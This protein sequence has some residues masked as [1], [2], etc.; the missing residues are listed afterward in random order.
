MKR[1]N[2]LYNLVMSVCALAVCGGCT[3]DPVSDQTVNSEGLTLEIN[4][5]DTP[6]ASV[7]T[8][9]AN[10]VSLNESNVNTVDVFFMKDD[11]VEHYVK[12][13][14]VNGKA[15]LANG[16]WKE[17]Y[18]GI[19]DVYVLANKHDYDNPS[20]TDVETDLS[21]VNNKTQ[22]LALTD[23]DT[24]VAKAEDEDYGSTK[25]SGKTFLMDGSISWNADD[26]EANAVIEVSLVHASAKLTV[27]LTY[28]E[29]FLTEGRKIVSVSKKLVHYVQDVKAFTEG[30]A[31]A[32]TEV[33]GESTSDGFSLANF[34][35]GENLSRRDK[36]YAYSYPNEWGADIAERET[37]FLINIPYSENDELRQNYYKVPVRIS[38]NASE[39]KLDRNMEYTVNVTVDRVGNESIDEPVPLKPTFSVATWKPVDINVDGDTPNYLVV[40]DKELEMHN[41]EDVAITFFSSSPI[42]VEIVSAY[43]VNKSG[44][45]VSVKND[46]L[47]STAYDELSLTGEITVHSDIPKNVTA[48]YITLKVTNEDEPTPLTQEIKIIQY[49]LEYISGVPGWYSTRDKFTATWQDHLDGKSFSSPPSVSNTVFSSK[50]YE[51]PY[52]YTYVV[53]GSGWYGDNPPFTIELGSSQ[54]ESK[55]NNRMYLVQ[56]TSTSSGHTVARPT[57]EGTGDD[58]V[59][60]SNEENNRLVSPVFMLA[61][62]LGTVTASGW[63]TAQEHCKQYVEWAKYPD[64]VTRKFADWRLPTFSELQIIAQYQ[65]EQPE[66]MDE[67]LGGEYYWSAYKNYCIIRVYEGNSLWGEYTD[68]WEP[69]PSNEQSDCFIRCI[70]DVTPED[71]EEF[72]AH[73]IQ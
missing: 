72:R 21:W 24:N 33:Q 32:L 3:E 55:S 14:V 38:G 12:S 47:I 31:L 66:V 39:L 1:N 56:I 60:Q 43:F 37:Y 34:T 9:G 49:P 64:G 71:L 5:G 8:R 19:Y 27:N 28:T 10:D 50:V 2:L 22:L 48:R 23:T 45:E 13:N 53:K 68:K 7:S 26:A 73:G 59:T 69:E 15:T 67:V 65:K 51:S 40:S 17:S 52:I 58:I 4:V 54:G 42:H 25:Y 6:A 46:R 35:N 41:E 18:T 62:Q 30:G 57:M 36:L 16:T 20:T 29:E 11:Q 44:D 63:S 61:S 70:R